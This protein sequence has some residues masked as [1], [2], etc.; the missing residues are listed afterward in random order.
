MFLLTTLIVRNSDIKA[1][2]YFISPEK[3]LNQT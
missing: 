1:G 2:I 3:V